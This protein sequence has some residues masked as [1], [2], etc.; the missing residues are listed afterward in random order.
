M[1]LLIVG[2]FTYGL[3]RSMDPSAVFEDTF[4]REPAANVR[5]IQSN[6]FWFVDTGSTYRVLKPTPKP[7]A[8]LS[9]PIC[10]ASRIANTSRSAGT[11]AIRDRIGG[12]MISPHLRKST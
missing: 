7:S 4:H 11:A 12:R 1:G 10:H 9:H 6:V 3:I 2:L 8:A 5:D